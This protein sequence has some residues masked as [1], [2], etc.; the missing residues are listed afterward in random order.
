MNKRDFL[1]IGAAGALG[2]ISSPLLAGKRGTLFSEPKEFVLPELPYPYDALE[3][4]ID[5]ETMIVHHTKHHAAYTAKLNEALKEAGLSPATVRELI[6]EASKYNTAIVNNAGGYLNHK[7]F[8]KC[9]SPSGG[10]NPSGN[11]ASLI[12]RDFGSF[13]AFKTL[14]NTQAKAIFGSGWTWLVLDGEKLK[15]VNTA[16]QDN[17]LMDTLTPDQKGFPL[18]CLD[19]WEH[20]YYLK[21]QN[22][23]AEYIDAF[24]NIVNW[25]LPNKKLEKNS[26]I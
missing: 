9:L 14:F 22:R 15:I 20:A 23:R 3:P 11:I 10:G 19:V 13:D 7:M 26:V 25:E 4:Y 1:K 24:W 18:L 6:V 17:P 8:W 16:N 5:K 12:D 2:L 21:Y